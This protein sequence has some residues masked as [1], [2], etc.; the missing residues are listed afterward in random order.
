MRFLVLMQTLCSEEWN[1]VFQSSKV[2]YLLSKH[3]GQR[4]ICFKAPEAETFRIFENKNKLCMERNLCDFIHL[5]LHSTK[6]YYC[7]YRNSQVQ[8]QNDCFSLSHLSHGFLLFHVFLHFWALF[9]LPLLFH[10]SAL[11]LLCFSVHRTHTH[12]LTCL[13]LCLSCSSFCPTHLQLV[14][15]NLLRIQ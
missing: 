13:C 9:C 10:S 7:T 3:L 5:L 15:L 2:K 1:V 11:S 12:T 14:L 4:E 8:G 6:S